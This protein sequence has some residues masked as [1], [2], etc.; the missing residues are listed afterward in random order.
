MVLLIPSNFFCLEG[1]SHALIPDLKKHFRGI[2]WLNSFNLAK[3]LVVH[4]FKGLSEF[5]FN[6]EKRGNSLVK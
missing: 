3:F 1:I 2:L 6:L 4:Y 5:S